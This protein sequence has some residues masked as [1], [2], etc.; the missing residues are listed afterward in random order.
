MSPLKCAGPCAISVAR[1][2]VVSSLQ[3]AGLQAISVAGA[4]DGSPSSCAGLQVVS[5][6][7]ATGVDLW[8]HS[9]WKARLA[10]QLGSGG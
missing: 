4:K 5:S 2:K 10:A 1:A 3:C 6:A 7:R 9:L 8:G